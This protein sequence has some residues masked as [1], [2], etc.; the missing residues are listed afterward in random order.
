MQEPNLKPASAEELLEVVAAFNRENF[1]NFLII[2]STPDIQRYFNLI[3]PGVPVETMP[4][5]LNKD[6]PP[7][8]MLIPQPRTKKEDLNEQSAASSTT[9]S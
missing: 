6:I 2:A 1:S 8:I 3:F 9:V 5:N 4:P 7:S